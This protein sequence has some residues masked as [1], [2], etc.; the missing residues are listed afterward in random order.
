M[1]L[2]A[3]LDERAVLA[4]WSAGEVNGGVNAAGCLRSW[5]SASTR[6]ATTGTRLSGRCCASRCPPVDTLAVCPACGTVAEA[7]APL[8][9]L[10]EDE[11][12]ARREDRSISPLR[13]PTVQDMIDAAALSADDAADLLAERCGL[14]AI[15]RNA[16]EQAA[17][18]LDECH[19]LLAPSFDVT[20]PGCGDQFSALLDAVELGWGAVEA[21]ATAIVD[22]VVAL[23]SA[24]GWSEAD[25]LTLPPR[26]RAVYRRI[27]EDGGAT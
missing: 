6:R 8:A 25:V 5:R 24:F 11:L 23:A 27:V 15:A 21:A 2:A 7:A 12:A 3:A 18:D 19:P 26:R 1:T 17:A 22:D 9:A 16:R 13:V 20:C 4:I 14:T 10:A